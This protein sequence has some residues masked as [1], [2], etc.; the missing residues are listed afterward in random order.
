MS[1]YDDDKEIQWISVK[2]FADDHPK[3]RTANF[4][5]RLTKKGRVNLWITSGKRSEH[6]TSFR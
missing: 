6:G 5:F 4:P 2:C 1:R 3:T